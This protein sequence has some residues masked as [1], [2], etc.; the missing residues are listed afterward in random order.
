MVKPQ[1]AAGALLLLLAGTAIGQRLARKYADSEIWVMDADGK[2]I[3]FE[4]AALLN[5]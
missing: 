1:R 3:V 4:K 2:Q 5:P